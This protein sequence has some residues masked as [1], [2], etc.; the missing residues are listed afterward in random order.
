MNFSCLL[1]FL[2]LVLT[3]E[4]ADWRAVWCVADVAAYRHHHRPLRATT[5]AQ[6]SSVR[7]AVR[8]LACRY[9]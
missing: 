5:E 2:S 9:K 8:L 6:T 3:S 4:A 1:R 7:T